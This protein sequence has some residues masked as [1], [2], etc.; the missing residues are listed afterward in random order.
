MKTI[1]SLA[2]VFAAFAGTL[3]A[4]APTNP[5]KKEQLVQPAQLAAELKTDNK[6]VVINVGP[7]GQIKGAQKVGAV[8]EPAGLQ[9]FNQTIDAL[10]KTTPVVVYCGCCTSDNCPNIRPAF[11]A[12]ADK[13]FK[14]IRVLE[15]E[16]GYVEDW[17]GKGFPVD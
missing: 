17:S 2:L 12:L 1:L 8:S 10:P 15:I 14:H 16:H 11:K 4:Q 13:G 3:R 9:K 7:M 5:W 6:P